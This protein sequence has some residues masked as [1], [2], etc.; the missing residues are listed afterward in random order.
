M[1]RRDKGS[2]TQHGPAAELAL[3]VLLRKE[4]RRMRRAARSLNRRPCSFLRHSPVFELHSKS[5]LAH[6]QSFQRYNSTIQMQAERKEMDVLLISNIS[7]LEE[8]LAHHSA[9]VL[10]PQG[11][12]LRV[13]RIDSK[14]I[15]KDI[16]PEAEV[17]ADKEIVPL[18]QNASI[19]LADPGLLV[20]ILKYANPKNLRWLQSSWAGVDKL[21]ASS[22]L[23]AVL[24]KDSGYDFALSRLGIFLASTTHPL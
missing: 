11:L 21:F 9:N 7:G 24:S 8:R 14:S 22:H 19:I 12:A 17:E 1:P 3:S 13:G 18:M 20:R 15:A 10:A 2:G 6:Y 5:S 23:S 4:E 16:S